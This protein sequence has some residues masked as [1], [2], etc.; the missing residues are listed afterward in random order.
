MVPCPDD[1]RWLSGTR[2]AEAALKARFGEATAIRTMDMSAIISARQGSSADGASDRPTIL[3][4]GTN[5]REIAWA[6]RAAALIDGAA[7][8]A[9]LEE[10]LR[11]A[12]RSI[13]IVG[14]DF[15][16]RIR[17]RQDAARED[18]PPLGELLRTLVE[19]RPDLSVRILVWSTSLIHAPGDIGQMLFGAPWQEHPR[20]RIKLD[21]HHPFYAAHHQKIVVVD[22]CIAFVGGIDLTVRRWDTPEHRIGDPDRIDPDGNAYPP[23]HD[24]QMVVDGDAARAVARVAR[25]R[26]RNACNEELDGFC[27]EGD[28]PWPSTTVPHFRGVRV[29][30][31]RTIPAFG[32]R[33]SVVEAARLTN[34]AIASAR[35]A[36]YIEAQYLTA[37]STGRALL[38][39][40][41][42]PDGPEVVILMTHRSHAL[43]EQWIMGAN[44]DR[45]IRRLARA[46]HNGRLRVLY[47]CVPT[48]DGPQQVLIHAKLIIV[49]DVFV[50]IG[51]SNLNNRS[52]GLDTELDLGIEAADAEDRFAIRDLR[53]EL[54]AEHLGATR[55]EVAEAIGRTGSLIAAIDR[56]NCRPRCLKPFEALTEDGPTTP[57]FLTPLLDPKRRFRRTLSRLWPFGKVAT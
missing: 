57:V 44:R 39:R 3:H 1:L 51:S 26:W 16:G 28:D 46:D 54:V 38:R 24:I 14:W 22:D 19:E 37:S 31:A 6:D 7:Y 40:L 25:D 52:I 43:I 13:L 5:C 33:R 34:D 50:R 23:V 30:V 9:S 20:I 35:Q 10:A 27:R 21:T 18:S 17:L 32:L 15:D 2:K 4:A 11:N 8:F 48:P 47:P 55:A 36:I 12:R 56:L 42:E 29:A 45:L 49:D 41:E 53:D